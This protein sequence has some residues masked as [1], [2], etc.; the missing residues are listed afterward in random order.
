VHELRVLK[1]LELSVVLQFFIFFNLTKI[2]VFKIILCVLIVLKCDEVLIFIRYGRVL[3]VGSNQ[4]FLHVFYF[5]LVT[6]D[7]VIFFKLAAQS[8]FDVRV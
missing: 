7:L 6:D 1:D 5:L 3:E 4:V 8:G 2:F